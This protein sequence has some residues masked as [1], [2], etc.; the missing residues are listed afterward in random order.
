LIGWAIQSDSQGSEVTFVAEKKQK[1]IYCMA[2]SRGI[3]PI[4]GSSLRLRGLCL[5]VFH[6]SGL[7]SKHFCMTNK[8]GPGIEPGPAV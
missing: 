5:I 2:F 8:P 6:A 7:S 1:I 3:Q 4:S